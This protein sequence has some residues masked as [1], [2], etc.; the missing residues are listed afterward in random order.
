MKLRS[1][2]Y[3]GGVQ[4]TALL[5]LAAQGR[6]DFPLFLFANTGDDSEDDD[7]LAYVRTIAKP[8]AEDHGI[9]LVELHK[10]RRNGSQETL[11]PRLMKGRTAI[12]VR[13]SRNGVPM[14][15]SCT[16][17]FKIRVIAKELGRRGASKADPALV[18]LGIS[19]DEADRANPGPARTMCAEVIAD[20]GLPVP[21]KSAC[22]FCPFHDVDAWRRLQRLKPGRFED[23]CL[24]ERTLSEKSKDGRPVYL[25]R[26]GRPLADVVGDQP[27][28]DGMDGCDSGWCMT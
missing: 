10:V 27:Q 8:Y 11:R 6:I 9:E 19:V 7:T 14:S 2:S 15:R 4:S 3:G 17:E 20:G 28:L 5:V 21:P 24:I 26:A 22:Y 23:A 12:P 16:A 1:V 25:T 13:R 18:A